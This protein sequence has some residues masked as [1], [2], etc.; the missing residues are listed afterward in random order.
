MGNILFR[1]ERD[2]QHGWYHLLLN[3]S[4][5]R[6]PWQLLVLALRTVEEEEEEGRISF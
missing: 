3:L 1:L 4:F 6:V 5:V 2:G